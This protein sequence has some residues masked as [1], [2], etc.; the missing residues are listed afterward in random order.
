M[1]IT[2]LFNGYSIITL[3]SFPSAFVERC[4]GLAGDFV[5]NCISAT[6]DP[7]VRWKWRGF[8]SKSYPWKPCRP[9]SEPQMESSVGGGGGVYPRL[10]EYCIGPA[11]VLSPSHP[12]AA[13]CLQPPTW[14]ITQ[15]LLRRDGPVL[16]R[17]LAWVMAA[18]PQTES[19]SGGAASVPASQSGWLTGNSDRWALSTWWH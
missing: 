4:S 8:L 17:L 18:L 11:Q 1:C 10:W 12:E 13:H 6:V 3:F 19:F 7:R 9:C 2:F 14:G 5:F 15:R 16:P